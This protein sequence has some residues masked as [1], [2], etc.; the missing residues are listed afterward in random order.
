MKRLALLIALFCFGCDDGGSGDDGGSTPQAN[1]GCKALC[2]QQAS[3]GCDGFDVGGCEEACAK[4]IPATCESAVTAVAK[5]LSSEPKTSFSCS[6]KNVDYTGSGCDDEDARLGS[7][8]A[9]SEPTD[10]CQEYCQASR[11]AGCPAAECEH[12]C[13]VVSRRSEGC[14]S[15]FTALYGCLLTLPET[16]STCTDMGISPAK[17]ECRQEALTYAECIQGQ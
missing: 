6:G 14:E 16:A 11:D 1:E 15:Q 5:C 8:L 7:C 3:V 13:D 17:D 12:L 4:S 9:P 2:A 10:I